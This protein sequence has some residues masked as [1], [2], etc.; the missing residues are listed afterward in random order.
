[1]P[2]DLRRQMLALPGV[3]AGDL[4]AVSERF[5]FAGKDTLDHAEIVAAL[6]DEARHRRFSHTL[7][8]G[9]HGG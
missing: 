9:F 1:M 4:K 2:K 3:T 8:I 6:E 5:A 7:P